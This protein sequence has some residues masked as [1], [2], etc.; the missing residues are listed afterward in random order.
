MVKL[1]TMAWWEIQRSKGNIESTASLVSVVAL[2][3]ILIAAWGASTYGFHTED[4]LYRVAVDDPHLATIIASNPKFDVVLTNT[5]HASFKD[6]FDLLIS[7][8]TVRYSHSEKSIAALDALD[9]TIRA[10]D[11]ARLVATGNLPNAF[12]VWVTVNYLPRQQSFQV[13]TT[14]RQ[15]Y[16]D[17]TRS[18]RPEKQV[19]TGGEEQRIPVSVESVDELGGDTGL[20]FEPQNVATPTHL[21][22]PIP[23]RSVVLTF[24]FIF[25][26]Y[27]IAQFYSASIMSE[28]VRRSGVVLLSAPLRSFEIALG[29][30]LPYLALTLFIVL[31]ISLGIGGSALILPLLLPVVLTF[32]STSFFAAILARSFKELTFVL[33]FLSVTLSGY[34]F[35]PAMFVNVHAVSSISPMSLVVKLLEGE[36][37]GLPEYLFSSTPLYLISLLALLFGIF[38]Y[39]EEDLFSQNS[40]PSKL[41][42]AIDVFL[43]RLKHSYLS[44]FSLSALLIPVAFM[45]ELMLIVVLFNLPIQL[46]IPIFII[47]AALVEES[48]KSLGIYTLMTR[49]KDD[50]SLKKS[51]F[52]GAASGAGFFVGEKLLMLIVLLSLADSVFGIAMGIGLLAFP[53]L[54]HVTTTTVTSLGLRLAGARFY[55]AAVVLAVMLHTAYNLY[56]LWGV[57]SG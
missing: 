18:V 21:Q 23:F 42:N 15:A 5:K 14:N 8:N 43:S 34:L 16:T 31:L 50:I 48:L 28:R 19:D 46:S 3:A 20:P 49:G 51:V 7:D 2:L 32:L 17:T 13:P 47:G 57:I 29:K 12:P 45:F 37:V 41:I 36:G 38:L 54:L 10:Y 27:F 11:E 35:F 4:R 44:V 56:L 33:V 55:A 9:R 30:M 22:P 39:R 53:L 52:L 6:S 25:P 24:F 26:M 40:L 1:L